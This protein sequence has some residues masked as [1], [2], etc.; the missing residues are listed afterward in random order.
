MELQLEVRMFWLFFAVRLSHCNIK[1][2]SY[3]C[4]WLFAI[5]CPKPRP[6][7]GRILGRVLISVNKYCDGRKEAHR[8]ANQDNQGAST[9]WRWEWAIPYRA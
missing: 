1:T 6:I 2:N 9:P 7:L 8:Q 3:S 4:L 5:I